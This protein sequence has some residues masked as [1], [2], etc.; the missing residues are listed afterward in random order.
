MSK[1]VG[2]NEIISKINQT[3]ESVTIKAEKINFNGM[4]TANKTFKIDTSGYMQATGG[5]VGGWKITSNSLENTETATYVKLNSGSFTAG[6]WSGQNIFAIGTK[7][8]DGKVE[9]RWGV[10]QYGDMYAQTVKT[11]GLTVNMG[12][13]ISGTMNFKGLVMLS[14]GVQLT[15]SDKTNIS[16]PSNKVNIV[17][18][19]K[20]YTLLNFIKGVANGSIT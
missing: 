20:S 3:A 14:A 5:K 11:E 9:V 2:A 4:I 12:G 10:N 8:S 6:T 1:K 16:V 18:G 13:T 7:G 19:G 17:H 15:N